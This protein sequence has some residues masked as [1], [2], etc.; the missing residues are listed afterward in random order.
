ML[1]EIEA[2]PVTIRIKSAP[3]DARNTE[4][5]GP[6]LTFAQTSV[7]SRFTC[8]P[9]DAFGNLRDDDDLFYLSTQ[10]LLGDLLL[11]DNLGLGGFGA[12]R[13]S[14]DRLY[15]PL[16]SCFNYAVT[17]QKVSLA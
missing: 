13:I 11:I 6:G 3:T 17:P 12:E 4:C 10:L 1:E 14:P 7:E 5:Y 2:S 9:R 8:C 16:T 15:D